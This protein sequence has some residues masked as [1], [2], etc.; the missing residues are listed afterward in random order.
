MEKKTC[1]LL[2]TLGITSNYYGYYYITNA[3]QLLMSGSE[4]LLLITKRLLPHV[5]RLNSTSPKNVE[6]DI[7]HSI[8]IA[9]RTNPELL[10]ELAGHPLP[11]KPTV[12]EFLS[13]LFHKIQFDED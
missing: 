9:W 8:E 1:K 13:I 2:I 10:S 7:R 12:G 5:A 11:K 4:N 3:L 6:R